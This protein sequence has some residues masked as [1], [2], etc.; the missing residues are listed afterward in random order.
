MTIDT[1]PKLS[2][3]LAGDETVNFALFGQTGSGKSR[4]ARRLAE[5]MMARDHS[6]FVLDFQGE[7]GDWAD[8]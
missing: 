8:G 1:T 3:L 7:H 6:L 4:A 2:S 5:D